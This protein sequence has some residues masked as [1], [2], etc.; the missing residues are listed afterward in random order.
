MLRQPMFNRR[1]TVVR[2]SKLASDGMPCERP[3]QRGAP[4]KK[5]MAH[6]FVGI[7]GYRLTVPCCVVDMSATG[8]GAMLC[9]APQD[10]LRLARDLPD[11][12]ILHLA[13]DRIEVDCEIQ[14]R[15]GDRFGARFTSIPRRLE[16]PMI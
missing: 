14:W 10:R 12:V 8:A 1:A 3:N 4:R 11:H 2:R 16:R 13:H 5:I 7:P 6:G 15:Q 9:A